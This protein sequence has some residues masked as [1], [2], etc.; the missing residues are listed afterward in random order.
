MPNVVYVQCHILT[1]YDEC[2]YAECRYAE[3]RFAEFRY[4]E[5]R[6]A[7][8]HY[9]ECRYAECRYAEW[10]GA[11]FRHHFDVKSHCFYVI[12]SP[13]AQVQYR[14]YSTFSAACQSSCS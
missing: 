7:E 9:A 3:C 11:K 2:H 6:Y 1:L 5:C 10:R 4:A 8:C 14:S 12:L 13:F